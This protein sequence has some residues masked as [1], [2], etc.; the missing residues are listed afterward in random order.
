MEIAVQAENNCLVI[1]AT[2]RL[3]TNTASEFKQRCDDCFSVTVKKIILDFS[4]LEYISS[5]GLRCILS[6]ANKLRAN[7]GSLVLCG[8]SGLVEEVIRI[9]GFD[10]FLP[11][12]ADVGHAMRGG[13]EGQVPM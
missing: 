7:G 2:G 1:K 9:S 13:T 10:N 12:F 11:N 8:L 6:M 5:A 3:D 4:Q